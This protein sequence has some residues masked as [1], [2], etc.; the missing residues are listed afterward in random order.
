[1]YQSLYFSIFQLLWVRFLHF[2]ELDAIIKEP[3]TLGWYPLQFISE[4]C[5]NGIAFLFLELAE[6]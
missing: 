3:F 6:P 5:T 4:V 2:L 1:M